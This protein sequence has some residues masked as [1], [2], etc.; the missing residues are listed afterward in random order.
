MKKLLIALVMVGLFASVA[1]AQPPGTEVDSWAYMQDE[2]TGEW[3]WDWQSGPGAPNQQALAR[4]F[5]SGQAD[6]ACNKD[7][8]IF[9][10]VHA[11]V[12]QWIEWDFTGTRWDWFV[13]KPGN[14]AANCFTWWLSSNQDVTIDFHDFG[15]LVA[16]DPKPG[17]DEEIE[18]FYCFDPPEGLPPLKTDPLWIPSYAMNDS[19][20]WWTIPD[21]Y[22]L[23]WEGV[24]LKIWNYIHVER[25]N[26]ACEYHDDAWITLTLECQK[27]WIDRTTGWYNF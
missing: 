23:H 8:W 18:I 20:N 13:R 7:W 11:S 19:I 2:E 1:Y 12:A 25:C 24:F 9:F 3:Y 21:S 6:S 27:P 14:Y 26:S 15:P 10:Q 16:E 4:C 5:A 22:N 17:Q